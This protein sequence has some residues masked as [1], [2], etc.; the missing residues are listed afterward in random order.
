[1]ETDQ[2]LE[3]IIAEFIREKILRT[4][5][6]EIPHAI[7]VQTE[8]LE[9]VKKKDLYRIRAI[10]YTEHE[11]QKGMI[12]GK[13]GSAIKHIGSEAR[14][15]LEHIL[16]CRVYLDLSVKVR[17]NWRRDANQIRRFGYGEGL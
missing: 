3:V 13:K 6:D 7:G 8:E 14:I 15:D 12:I 2:P 11:S 5:R 1:M 10:I 17:K 16:G 9:Y 4:F